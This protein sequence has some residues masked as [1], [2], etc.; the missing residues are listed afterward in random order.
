MAAPQVEPLYLLEVVPELRLGPLDQLGGGRRV[1]FAKGVYVQPLEPFRR[2]SGEVRQGLPEPAEFVGGI[3]EVR[4][5]RAVLRIDAQAHAGTQSFPDGTVAFQFGEAIEGQV[6]GQAGQLLK[7]RRTVY[8]GIDV[9]TPAEMAVY[10]GGLVHTARRSPRQVLGNQGKGGPVSEGLQR[11]D[12]VYAAGRSHISNQLQ[13]TAQLVCF[14]D[15]GGGGK[16]HAVKLIRRP[17]A[18]EPRSTGRPR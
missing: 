17:R 13:V 7:F 18:G 3:V 9:R 12:D 2:L 6:T 15:E 11:Q 10:Q 4:L 1:A 8:G 16:G 5:H 14:D